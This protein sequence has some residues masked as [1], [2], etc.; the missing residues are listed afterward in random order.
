MTSAIVKFQWTPIFR[1]VLVPISAKNYPQNRRNTLLYFT[2]LVSMLEL[3]SPHETPQKSKWKRSRHLFKKHWPVVLVHDSAATLGGGFNLFESKIFVKLDHFPKFAG[4][5]FPKL[6][7][8]AVSTHL[9]SNSQIGNLPQ[10]RV[11]IPKIFELPPSSLCSTTQ[12]PPHNS[13]LSV[14]KMCWSQPKGVAVKIFAPF[15][16]G[17]FQRVHRPTQKH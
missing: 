10:I 11:K 3:G 15:S 7:W 1:H 12:P 6:F 9:K 8:L 14:S 4:N 13:F 16:D 5:T 17:F 2:Q